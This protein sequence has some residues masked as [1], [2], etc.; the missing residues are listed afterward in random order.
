MSNLIRNS[1]KAGHFKEL[2]DKI[3]AHKLFSS[4]DRLDTSQMIKEED[5]KPRKVV[6]NLNEFL[7][8]TGVSKN[9]VSDTDQSYGHLQVRRACFHCKSE[10]DFEAM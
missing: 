6:K 10:F 7:N 1:K 9:K 8:F 3:A 2:K 4:L 5:E